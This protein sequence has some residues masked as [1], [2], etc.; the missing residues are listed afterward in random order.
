MVLRDFSC[1]YWFFVLLLTKTII[2][3]FP[4]DFD[5]QGNTVLALTTFHDSRTT[6]ELHPRKL[7][8]SWKVLVR[9]LYTIPYDLLIWEMML[10]EK[11]SIKTKLFSWETSY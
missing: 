10:H 1:N 11:G 3:N 7:L 6:F 5:L 2:N 9:V 4:Q 8:K